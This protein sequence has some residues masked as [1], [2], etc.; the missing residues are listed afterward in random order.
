MAVVVS[1]VGLRVT[2]HLLLQGYTYKSLVTADVRVRN[3]CCFFPA[4]TLFVFGA[5]A[6]Q[7][8]RTSS[9]TKFLDHTQRRTTVI[10]TPLD[11]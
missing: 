7:W 1:V 4:I 8:A 5:T 2:Y 11:E 10:R 6:P 9:C 3:V